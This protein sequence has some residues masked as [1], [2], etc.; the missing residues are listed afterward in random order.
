MPKKTIVLVDDSGSFLF[1]C[2][3]VL[4][5]YYQVFPLHSAEDMFKLLEEVTPDLILLDV[6]MP[7]MGGYEAIKILKDTEKYEDIPVIFLTGMDDTESEVEGLNLGAVDYFHKPLDN[8]LLI[9]RIDTHMSVI[10]TKKELHGL[11]LSIEKALR[12]NLD[13]EADSK[14]IKALVAETEYLFK[15]GREIREPLNIIIEMIETA[16]KSDD[17]TEIKNCLGRADV[18]TRLIL[19][20]VGGAKSMNKFI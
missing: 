17:I 18:E 4:K 16:I 2:E 10:E 9:K 12:E 14:T 3:S 13:G 8:T 6:M 20:I 7:D 19:E 15:M 11:K 5:E 1:S